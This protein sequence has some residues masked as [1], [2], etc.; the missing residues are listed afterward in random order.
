M[1][2]TTKLILV[3][4]GLFVINSATIARDSH[5]NTSRALGSSSDYRGHNS[6]KSSKDLGYSKDRKNRHQKHDSSNRNHRQNND[7]INRNHRQQYNSNTPYSKR[8]QHNNHGNYYRNTYKPSPQIYH[9]VSK[10]ITVHYG[11]YN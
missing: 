8:L 7:S 1:N 2:I 10:I 11:Q 9:P 4:A 5:Q 3:A 6:Q